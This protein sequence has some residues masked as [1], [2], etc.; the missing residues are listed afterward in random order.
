VIRRWR[1]ETTT[2]EVDMRHIMIIT[3]ALTLI[4]GA[5]GNES[6]DPGTAPAT[7]ET[8]AQTLPPTTTT[9]TTTATSE[10]PPSPAELASRFLEV[11]YLEIDPA[12]WRVLLPDDAP[13]LNPEFAWVWV[14]DYDEDGAVSQADWVQFQ[15]ATNRA[16]RSD[17]EWECES[18]SDDTARCVVSHTSAFYE[19]GGASPPPEEAL[20]T[21]EAGLLVEYETVEPENPAEWDSLKDLAEEGRWEALARYE[22]WVK[23][24]YP[25]R[26]SAVF[27]EGVDDWVVLPS[28]VLMHEELM[29]EY[30]D[31]V[32]SA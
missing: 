32:A 28:A 17:A 16:I 8:V 26:Y 3:I 31:S 25:D 12:A 29:A 6:A 9:T 7:S 5:C 23:D 22:E 27:D 18:V 2:E 10:A 20:W 4:I 11:R 15:I 30:L 24:T 21:F 19:L 13:I 14:E 1:G